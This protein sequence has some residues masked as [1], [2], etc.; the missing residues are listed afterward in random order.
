MPVKYKARQNAGL[1]IVTY[2]T[3]TGPL[4][5]CFYGQENSKKKKRKEQKKTTKLRL[6]S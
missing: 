1:P 6:T 5:T 4:E 2:T 3:S